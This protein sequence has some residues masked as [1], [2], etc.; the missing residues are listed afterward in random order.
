LAV[1]A[2]AFSHTMHF[3][4]GT[5]SGVVTT[6]AGGRTRFGIAQKFHPELS[7]EFFSGPAGE[8]LAVAEQ[9]LHDQYWTP[10]HL[11]EVEDQAVA[12][13]LFD[14][15]VNMG[16]RQAVVYAQ[17]ALNA[18]QESRH[19]AERLVEDGVLGPATRAAIQAT[20]PDRYL[21][22]L[23]EFSRAHYLHVAAVNP[24]QAVNLDGWMKRADS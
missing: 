4:D 3:E 17:R 5:R 24:A 14:M 9:M 12:N 13:K 16:V 8:A 23:R 1:F 11:D 20:D 6:D 22:L 10:L 18:D 15:A 2:Q 21:Q 19:G 7:D